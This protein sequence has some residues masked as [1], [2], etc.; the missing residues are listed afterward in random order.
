MTWR[1]DRGHS[2][3]A[4]LCQIGSSA[5]AI[6]LVG[7]LLAVDGAGRSDTTVSTHAYDSRLNKALTRA[8]V[9]P[10]RVSAA[11][12]TS[13]RTASLATG[14]APAFAVPVV[15]PEDAGPEI[16][17]GSAGGDTAGKVFSQSVRQAALDENPSTCVYCHMDT[18]SPQIDHAIPRSARWERYDR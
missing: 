14:S 10:S 3:L 9:A 15:A 2:R 13:T 4:V 18:D 12:T 7:L 5:V 17:A 8:V 11:E 16:K 1:G 6:V